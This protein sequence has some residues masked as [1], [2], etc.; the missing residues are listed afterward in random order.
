MAD[1]AKKAQNFY[2]GIDDKAKKIKAIYIGDK[3]GKAKKFF[4][5]GGVGIDLPIELFNYSFL[6]ENEV[7]IYNPLCSEWHQRFPSGKIIFTNYYFP[8]II[9]KKKVIY[10]NEK[11]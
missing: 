2:I 3:D 4:S 8:E 9:D 11:I 5:E 7:A 1:I 6:S 10:Y